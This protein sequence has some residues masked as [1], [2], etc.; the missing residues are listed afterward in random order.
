MKLRVYKCSRRSSD[1][2][3][4]QIKLYTLILQITNHLI[5]LLFHL[6]QNKYNRAIEIYNLDTIYRSLNIISY[7]I[8]EF[9]FAL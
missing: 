9:S 5:A 3:I 7:R 1:N 8:R 6:L 2:L 4:K